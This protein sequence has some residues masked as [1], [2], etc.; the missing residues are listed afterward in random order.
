M[1]THK[2]MMI[3]AT[4]L[5]SVNSFANGSIPPRAAQ[6]CVACHG[7]NGVSINPIWPNLAGQKKEYLVK[8]LEDFRS[9]RRVDATMSPMAKTIS[10]DE[11]HQVAE[12]FSGQTLK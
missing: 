4:G 10:E 7:A 12:Y 9:G 1:K 2:L 11:V 6:A 5:C 8:Q 3:F